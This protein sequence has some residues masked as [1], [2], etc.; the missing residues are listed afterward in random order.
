MEKHHWKP[1]GS[2]GF[3]CNA[4]KNHRGNGPI[5]HTRNCTGFVVGEVHARNEPS[6]AAGSQPSVPSQQCVKA[7]MHVL[8]YRVQESAAF[9]SDREFRPAAF[10]AP[11]DE[12]GV[13][14]TVVK[15]YVLW[16]WPRDGSHEMHSPLTR[17]QLD[18][19][20][21]HFVQWDRKLILIVASVFFDGVIGYRDTKTL[22]VHLSLIHI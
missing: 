20:S 18:V 22:K 10:R 14:W 6:V 19:H 11:N 8:L 17:R 4:C 16:R 15:S 21:N 1:A 9:R 2:D 7:F 3:C 13:D 12:G 5:R